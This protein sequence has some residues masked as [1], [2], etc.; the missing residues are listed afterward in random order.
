[1]KAFV[2]RSAR[3]A[4][5]YV[6]LAARDDFAV[7]PAALRERLG[8]LAFVVEVELDA[9]RRLPRADAAVVRR[10]LAALGWYVQ[11]PERPL[12]PAG[13]A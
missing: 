7:L 5:T 2:Y 12:P 9:A 10:T 13:G 3:R 4:D 1:M 6:W 11:L 8:A